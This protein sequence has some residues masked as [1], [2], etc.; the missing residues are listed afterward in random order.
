[1]KTAILLINLG[2]PKKPS[3]AAVR[4]Y[5]REFLSDPLVI[6]L[7][8]LVRTIL[9]NLILVNR[10][11]ESAKAYQAVWLPGGSPLLVYTRE[12][13][14]ALAQKLGED[15]LVEI[16]M[17]YGEPSISEA[18]DKLLATQPERL[19]IFPLFPQ[20]SRAVTGSIIE[21]V[22]QELAKKKVSIPVSIKESFHDDVGYV[23]SYAALAKQSMAEIDADY[24]LLS[25]HGLPE[26]QMQYN[27]NYQKDCFTTSEG[28]AK[29]LGLDAGCYQTS[30]QSR[31]GRTPWI[32]PYTDK[33]LVQ[34]REQ[35]VKRLAVACPSFV[36]D[37]LETLEE[38]GMRAH[39]EWLALGGEK[40]VLVP[41]LNS[42]ETWVNV[43]IECLGVK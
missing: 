7:P 37:C 42:S 2:T 32:Q 1:M 27:S 8:W 38:I 21:R 31:L 41:C 23:Q 15:Y 14:H 43:L 30:F 28:I 29:V 12:L 11:K 17:R 35:G 26:R 18:L 4:S 36:I 25:Y 6:D 9:V 5:L 39:E 10:P 33:V 20:Y 22:N 19:I 34:L 24:L 40:F 13:E 16:A 3:V